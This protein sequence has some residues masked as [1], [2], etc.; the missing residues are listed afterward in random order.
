MYFTIAF[1]RQNSHKGNLL[2]KTTRGNACKFDSLTRSP[3]SRCKHFYQLKCDFQRILTSNKKH[4]LISG[5]VERNPGPTSDLLFV[6][7]NR[8]F[9]IGRQPVNILGD[10]NCFF[11]SISHQFYENDSQHAQIRAHAIQHLILCPEYFIE[12]NTEQSWSQYL[13]NMSTIGTW[14]D[15]IIIQA[16]AN[17]YNL[18]IN[19]TESALNFSECTT[20]T[21][22]NSSNLR[23]VYIGHLDE[24]HYVSTAPLIPNQVFD[25]T[26]QF[27]QNDCFTKVSLAS[28]VSAPVGRRDSDSA[29]GGSRKEYMKQYM[30]NKRKSAEFKTMFT[31]CRY[32]AK[33]A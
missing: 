28:S 7:I 33:T 17:S 4:L 22:N 12:S 3:T 32:G 25:S 31:R 15:Q 10:G 30:W 11:R 9:R 27:Q 18:R 8:L 21:S 29:K 6:L 23:E 24:I 19:I 26:T 16:V 1:S 13:Q 5:D 14:A 20:V 2:I